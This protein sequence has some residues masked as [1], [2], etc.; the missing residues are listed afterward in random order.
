MCLVSPG[1]HL[2]VL[3]GG[4]ASPPLSSHM[5]RHAGVFFL[6]F[7]IFFLFFFWGGGLIFSCRIHEHLHCLVSD[8][9]VSN[10]LFFCAINREGKREK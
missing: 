5:S 10:Y 7:F 2:G 6:F 1:C 3:Y 4:K 9:C 8:R